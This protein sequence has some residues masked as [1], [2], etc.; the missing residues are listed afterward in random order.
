MANWDPDKIDGRDLG[1]FLEDQLAKVGLDPLKAMMLGSVLADRI[2]MDWRVE[3][4]TPQERA[5]T[6]LSMAIAEMET[7]M[8]AALQP[9]VSGLN[10]TL[11]SIK[12]SLSPS[13]KASSEGKWVR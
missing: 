6:K 8:V 7:S 3:A 9:V 13:K 2:K 12:N 4:K 11:I 1:E 5:A 10:D